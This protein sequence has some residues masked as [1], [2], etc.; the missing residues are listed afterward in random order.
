MEEYILCDAIAV[1][2]CIPAGCEAIGVT[3]NE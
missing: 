2:V 1:S 3:V